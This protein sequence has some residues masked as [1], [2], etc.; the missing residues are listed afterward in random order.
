MES[1]KLDLIK[2]EILQL[3]KQIYKEELILKE[4]KIDLRGI[5]LIFDCQTKEAKAKILGKQGKHIKLVRRIVKLFGFMNY[6]ANINI[7][8]VPDVER[9]QQSAGGKNK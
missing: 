1:E 5:N 9:L 7:F 6:K 2:N 8:L 3:L 4:A